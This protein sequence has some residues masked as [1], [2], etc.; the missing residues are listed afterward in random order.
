MSMRNQRLLEDLAARRQPGRRSTPHLAALPP[1]GRQRDVTPIAGGCREHVVVDLVGL[2]SVGVES[3]GVESVGVES[4]G[5]ER[6]GVQPVGVE[7]IAVESVGV[8]RVEAE[9]V[10]VE[11]LIADLGALVD[12][13]LVV[14]ESHVLGPTR[15]AVGPDLEDAA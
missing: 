4:V 5:V 14:V 1:A 13:G 6:V 11:R 2:E 12:A 8:E 15:Y 10:E 3:V 9:R 7:S